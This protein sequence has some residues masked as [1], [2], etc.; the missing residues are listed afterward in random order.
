MFLRNYVIYTCKL[1]LHT[2]Y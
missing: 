1:F 2:D